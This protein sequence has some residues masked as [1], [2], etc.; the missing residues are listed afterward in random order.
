MPETAEPAVMLK[1]AKLLRS[2][3]ADAQERVAVWTRRMFGPKDQTG[4]ERAQRYRDGHAVTPPLRNGVTPRDE[5]PP[6]VTV[7]PRDEVQKRTKVSNNSQGLDYT[8]S[9][10]AFWSVY[11]KRVGK[12]SAF[13]SWKRSGCES[14]SE[15]VVKAVREQLPYLNR[16][17]G[18][19]RPLPATWLNQKRWQ[20]D[21][22]NTKSAA[23]SAPPS[24]PTSVMDLPPLSEEQV[25]ENVARMRDLMQ[26]ISKAP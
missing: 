13:L 7:K 4:A 23:T 14:I 12:G 19:Y 18:Q 10:E 1:I 26:G 8:Q 2:L 16:E 15:V 9:F 20:D 17:G 25:A 22:Y 3:P 21:P 5:D 6:N 11:P 24:Q